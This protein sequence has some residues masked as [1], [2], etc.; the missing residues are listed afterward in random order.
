LS[1]AAVDSNSVRMSRATAS[2]RVL[3][4]FGTLAE[5]VLPAS[6]HSALVD[7]ALVVGASLFIGL[8]AQISVD[9]PAS[10]VPITGQS[11]GVLLVGM[12][13]G[14][15]RGLAAVALYLMEGCMGMPVFA[16]G[17]FGFGKMIGPT[18]GYLLGF[19]PAAWLA[20]W[21]AERGWDRD[22]KLALLAML[23]GTA[24]IFLFGVAWLAFFIGFEAAFWTG[25]VPFLP[26]GVIKATLGM[27]M[28]PGAWRFVGELRGRE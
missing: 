16:G 8:T 21:L 18:G 11:L 12:A 9:L 14:A 1:F 3:A 15:K 22:D 25:F 4:P 10:L 17:T 27:A 26:G 20:G 6:R 23:A 13:L 2:T 28:L 7:A 5:Q 19:A 24:V